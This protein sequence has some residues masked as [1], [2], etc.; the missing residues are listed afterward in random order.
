MFD[1]LLSQDNP[2]LEVPKMKIAVISD[3][4]GKMENG[5]PFPSCSKTFVCADNREHP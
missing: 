3:V 4:H 2:V 5:I 1:K